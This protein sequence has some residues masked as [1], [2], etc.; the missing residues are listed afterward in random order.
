MIA[1]VP[2]ALVSEITAFS[3][4][5]VKGVSHRGP[6]GSTPSS[7]FG[8]RIGRLDVAIQCLQDRAT[9]VALSERTLAVCGIVLQNPLCRAE[10]PSLRLEWLNESLPPQ[11]SRRGTFAN[12]LSDNVILAIR[13]K[14]R[15]FPAVVAD[16]VDPSSINQWAIGI[17]AIASAIF[18]RTEVVRAPRAIEPGGDGRMAD[19]GH[20]PGGR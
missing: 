4:Q 5:F 14:E 6:A 1:S 12:S 20:R 7:Q 17:L 19:H 18:D 16:T 15:F 3:F 9:K 11:R 10:R 2:T 13:N 8:L